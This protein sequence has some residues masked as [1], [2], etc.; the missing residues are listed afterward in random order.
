LAS[1]INAGRCDGHP[2]ALEK[3]KYFFPLNAILYTM[4][5]N[6]SALLLPADVAVT[7][8][9]PKALANHFAEKT[10]PF[11]TRAVVNSGLSD[12]ARAT[13]RHGG[14]DHTV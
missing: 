8:V 3:C 4:R 13:S 2:A 6:A 5:C 11:L 1:D 14:R 7:F 10:L 12:L 9:K